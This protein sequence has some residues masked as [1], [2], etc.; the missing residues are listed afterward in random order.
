[1][2]PSR[3]SAIARIARSDLAASAWSALRLASADAGRAR[4]GSNLDPGV[5]LRGRPVLF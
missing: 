4:L 1:M 3:P 5:V 2:V